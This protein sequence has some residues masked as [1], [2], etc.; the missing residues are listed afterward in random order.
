MTGRSSTALHLLVVPL[1]LVLAATLLQHSALDVAISGVFFDPKAQRFLGERSGLFELLGH[2][3][4]RGLP[5]AVGV[6]ALGVAVGSRWRPSLRPLR[7]LAVALALALVLTPVV[8]SLLKSSTAA[9]CP[10][11][12]D[13][14]G[15]RFDYLAE[16]DGPFWAPASTAAGRCLPSAHAGAGYGLLALYFF[17]WAAGLRRWRWLG[18]AAGIVAGLLFSLVR[19]SQGSHFA[20]QTVW[21]AAVAWTI[22]ALVFA[23][24]LGS[25]RGSRS[26]ATPSAPGL[27]RRR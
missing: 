10:H 24:W 13:V 21:S 27:G 16:R 17:G 14:F 9:H 23:P 18:L 7:W 3:A 2:Q 5:V 15:G 22:G 8:I 6:V 25:L 4:A 26:T 12:M 20:S 11:S 19:I 1:L